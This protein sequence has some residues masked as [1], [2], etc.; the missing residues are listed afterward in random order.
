[1][2]KVRVFLNNFWKWLTSFPTSLIFGFLL[3]I[4]TTLGFIKWNLFIAGIVLGLI[5]EQLFIGVKKA[6]EEWHNLRPI[7]KILG[8]IYNDKQCHIYFST[9]YR[10]LNKPDKFKLL[11]W[12]KIHDGKEIYVNGPAF[13]LG[14]GDSLAISFILS[15]L[16]KAKI[17]QEQIYIERS[18]K[19]IEKWGEGCFCI[20]AHNPKTRIILNKFKGLHFRF[21][22]NYGVITTADPKDHPNEGYHRGVYIEP[23]Y[24]PEP[25]DYG[26]LIKIKD[27][28]NKPN[29]TIF[30][31]AG[32]GPA[33]TSGAAYYL[34]NN[35]RELSEIGSEFELLIQVPSGYQSARQVEFDKVANYYN[36]IN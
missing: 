28:F 25:T 17:E 2:N 5:L 12:N 11:L 23:T 35:F 15:L 4:L 34:L 1:M 22:N 26:L 13:V 18:E 21:D 31:I 14:E 36:P 7:N 10:D 27:Q 3:G 29:K 20:G 16:S 33:G 30:I 19:E 32:I 8:S 24:E 6:Y 9:F